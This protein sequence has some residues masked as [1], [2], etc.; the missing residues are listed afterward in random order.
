[1]PLTAVATIRT[2]A[3]G[4]AIRIFSRTPF[5][6]HSLSAHLPERMRA[7]RRAVGAVQVGRVHIHRW[8]D[9]SSHFHVWFQGRPARQLELYGWGNILWSQVAEPLS[10]ASIDAN[11]TLVIDHFSVRAGGVIASR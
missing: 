5:L 6:T 2:I 7:I 4:R 11:H 10:A 8:G 9:G 1:M 3:F